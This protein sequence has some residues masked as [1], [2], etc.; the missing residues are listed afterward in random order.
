MG[1]FALF[2]VG[3]LV[4]YGATGVCRIS[5]VTVRSFG[6]ESGEYFVLRP[7]YDAK[8]T[9]FVPKE[10]SL[11]TQK[12]H[13]VL[14]PE[15]ILA[16]VSDYEDA[17]EVHIKEDKQRQERYKQLVV[18]GDRRKLARIVKILFKL[19]EEMNA[20]GK[21]LRMADERILKEAERLL[22]DEIS[23]SFQLERGQV[24]PFLFGEIKP[25]PKQ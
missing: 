11:L 4:Y 20:A 10:N 5:D 3:D 13:P 12:I 25:E 16:M 9:L 21:K 19:R 24:I 18:T 8:S 22:Y 2:K 23:L 15:E 17:E 14:M 1:V 7:I 6:T